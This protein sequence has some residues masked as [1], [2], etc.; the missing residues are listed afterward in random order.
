MASSREG[1]KE[2]FAPPAGER[3]KKEG[4]KKLFFFLLFLALVFCSFIAQ[5]GANAEKRWQSHTRYF[6]SKPLANL[7]LAL[8]VRELVRLLIM[9][10]AKRQNKIK[11]ST[12][13]KNVIK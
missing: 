1:V 5:P 13:P 7:S 12:T 9:F 4:E 10:S 6:M 11:P 2:R 8:C 3:E